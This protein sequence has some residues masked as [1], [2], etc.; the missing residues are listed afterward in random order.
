[1]IFTV[2]QLFE[3]MGTK[4]PKKFRSMFGRMLV[5]NIRNQHPTAVITRI[6]EDQ[7]GQIVEVNAYPAYLQ[8]FAFDLFLKFL[9]RRQKFHQKKVESKARNN[10][11]KRKRPRIPNTR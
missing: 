9:R 3:K 10:E 2:Y 8:E 1:M 7:D 5:A 6:Q 4:L 11:L